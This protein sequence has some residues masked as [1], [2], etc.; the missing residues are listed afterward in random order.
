MLK[1]IVLMVAVCLM[2][3][4]PAFANEAS[5]ITTVQVSG[6][7]QKEMTPDIA[8]ISISIHSVNANL[9]QAK[10]ENTT[11]ANR[12]LAKLKELGIKDEEIKTST[13]QIDSVYNYENNRLPKLKG[14]QVTN[15]LEITTS[16]EKVG[17]LVNEVTNAGAN[18]VNSIQFEKMN[19]VE[20]KE[21]ALSDAVADALRK[22]EV[23][24]SALHKQVA[25][26]KIVN[27][28]GVSYHPV[29]MES[30]AFKGMNADAGAVPSIAPGKVTVSANVQVTVELQ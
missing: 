11:N 18:E 30:R 21:A 8:K 3:A 24:A 20:I 14:Y 28:S 26:V 16:I 2:V 10:N 7:S 25:N 5:N 1:K 19:Q 22:A 4:V 6:N 17:I 29:M 13:Y 15:S 23:I 9:E 12:V 27:E